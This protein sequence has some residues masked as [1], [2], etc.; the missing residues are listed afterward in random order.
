M[1]FLQR[2]IDHF[3]RHEVSEPDLQEEDLQSLKAEALAQAGNFLACPDCDLLHCV[4]AM[5][6]GMNAKCSRCGCILVDNKSCSVDHS[7]AYAIAAAVFFVLAN[8]YPLLSFNIEGREGTCRIAEGAIQLIERGYWPLGIL[9][10]LTGIIAPL[11]IILG[12]LYVLIP[13]CMRRSHP[14]LPLAFRVLT[15]LRPWSMLDVFLLGAVVALIKLDDLSE[16]EMRLGFLFLCALILCGTM[17]I[18]AL[19]THK[20]WA[21]LEGES[22]Q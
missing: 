16:T 12:L 2:L 4:P 21:H 13:V 20:L 11:L 22:D 8:I 1:S 14:S 9:V 19:D 6:Q 3:R 5:R 10:L 17:A 18:N 7:L 15:S